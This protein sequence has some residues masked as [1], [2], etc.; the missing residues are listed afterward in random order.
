MA[1]IM[2]TGGN[3]FLGRVLVK[4]LISS[5]PNDRVSVLDLESD[6][7]KYPEFMKDAGVKIFSGRDISADP[8]VKEFEGVDTLLHLAGL[9]SFH[10]KDKESLRRINV[11]GTSQVMQSAFD[12]NVRKVINVSSIAALGYNNQRDSP[13]DE[14]FNFDWEIARKSEK[15]YML[16]K[17]Y[18]DLEVERFLKKGLNCSIAYPGLMLGPGDIKNSLPLVMA[19]A[20]GKIPFNMPGGNG[21]ID[22]R[23]VSKGLLRMVGGAEFGEDYILSHHNVSFKDLNKVV[24]EVIGV[25]PPKRTLPCIFERPLYGLLSAVEFFYKGRLPLTADL[26]ESSFKFRYFSNEKAKK[27]LGWNPEISLK[28]TIED[29]F[30]WA[31]KEGYLE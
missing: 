1:N 25:K 4:D 27:D 12:T 8:L 3:G 17:H 26:V 23:D 11:T 21:I 19:I 7:E 30:W 28:Q 6:L 9:V 18:A 10:R 29:T 5:Y 16:S 13:V 20:S 22:V 2:V 24:A 31:K 14:S 15:N